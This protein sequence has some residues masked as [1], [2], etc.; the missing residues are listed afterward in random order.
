[1]IRITKLSDYGTAILAELAQSPSIARCSARDIA[2]RS[3]IPLPMVSKI[4]KILAKKG[5]LASYRGVNGGYALSR[6]PQ[7][8][9]LGE[10]IS[11]LEGPVF[12]THCSENGECPCG[13]SGYCPVRGIWPGINRRFQEILDGTKL[14]DIL[15]NGAKPQLSAL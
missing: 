7:D 12:L 4:L 13:R 2:M 14:A 15:Q 11:A 8:I 1:M 6:A 9:S 10:I 3:D 5:L